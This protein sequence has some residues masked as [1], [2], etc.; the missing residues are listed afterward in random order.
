MHTYLYPNPS[1]T[2]SFQIRDLK[3]EQVRIVNVLGQLQDFRQNG[4][5]IQLTYPKAGIY[6]VFIGTQK[7]TLKVE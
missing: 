3:D 6:Q 7:A 5:L 2:G 1:N 4:D